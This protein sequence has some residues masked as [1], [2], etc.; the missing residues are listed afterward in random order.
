MKY[1]QICHELIGGKGKKLRGRVP[2][3]LTAFAWCVDCQQA[4]CEIHWKTR[5]ATHHTE[6]KELGVE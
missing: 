6:P 3:G 4:V 2:C 1:P 5:H